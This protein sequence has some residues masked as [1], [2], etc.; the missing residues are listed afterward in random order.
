MKDTSRLPSKVRTL[1]RTKNVE[2]LQ[3]DN[4]L[5]SIIDNVII[6]VTNGI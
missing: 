3:T 1:T 2:I 5:N 6:N 4:I